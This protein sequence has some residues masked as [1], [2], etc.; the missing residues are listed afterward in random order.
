MNKTRV[1]ILGAGKIG[2]YHAREFSSLGA[3]VV[4]ILGSSR[5]SSAKTAEKLEKDFGV[6]TKPYHV[7]EELLG[8]EKLDAVSI[9]TPPEMHASQIR[10]CLEKGLNVMCEKPFVQTNNDDYK[11]A[12]ELLDF[13]EKKRRILTVNTQWASI[14]DY[15]KGYTDLDSLKKFSMEAEPE[16]KGIGL[17]NDFL[18]HAN[19]VL[20]KMVPDGKV[21]GIE[22]L[23]KN[24][25]S[26]IVKFKYENSKKSV[27]VKYGFRT[28][29]SRPGQIVFSLN[30]KTFR[31]EIG[32]EYKQF[33]AANKERFEI[34]DPLRVSIRKFLQACNDY[35]VPLIS[36]KEIL[37]NIALTKQIIKEYIS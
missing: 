3:E 2:R 28:R 27:E 11:T 19:S 36:K 9:C 16:G 5:E 34:E 12:K 14:V 21:E 31:R 6:K 18:P 15:F 10:L 13:A 20:I 32:S 35:G 26:V 29:V 24:E 4:A 17:L 7:L 1:A 22:F 8:N 30:E 25:N 23:S 37:E 33:F